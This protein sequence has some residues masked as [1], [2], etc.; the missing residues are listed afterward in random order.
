MSF[1]AEA[2]EKRTEELRK[3]VELFNEFKECYKK[4]QKMW[5]GLIDKMCETVKHY[6]PSENIEEDEDTSLFS[7]YKKKF[8]RELINI[9]DNAVRDRDALLELYRNVK[10]QELRTAW[11]GDHVEKSYTAKF[12]AVIKQWGKKVKLL[13]EVCDASTIQEIMCI[14]LRKDNKLCIAGCLYKWNNPMK[15]IP[16]CKGVNCEWHFES[17]HGTTVLYMWIMETIHSEG[18]P[19]VIKEYMRKYDYPMEEF[20]AV[21]PDPPK[22]TEEEKEIAARLTAVDEAWEALQDHK[23]SGKYQRAYATAREKLD[24]LIQ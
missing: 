24:E 5:A 6:R 8:T 10:S 3:F 4:N 11:F 13:K 15:N 19:E 9:A 7:N 23:Y 1:T 16:I 14:S 22:L 21:F 17:L 2:R 20:L 18:G 12:N